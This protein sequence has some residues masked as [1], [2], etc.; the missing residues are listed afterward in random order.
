MDRRRGRIDRKAAHWALRL[1]ARACGPAERRRLDRWLERDPAH[2]T[3]LSEA[4]R[5]L[6]AIDRFAAAPPPL[7]AASSAGVRRSGRRPQRRLAAGLCG[8]AAAACLCL[9]LALGYLW[10]G[11]PRILIAADAATGPG[12]LREVR[13]PDGSAVTLGPE[14]AVAWDFEAGGRR[15]ELLAGAAVFSVVPDPDAGE[16]ASDRRFS[17]AAGAG[18]VTA[19]GTRFLVELRGDGVE[20]AVAEHAVLVSLRRAGGEARRE[21]VQGQGLRYGPAG[22]GAV[23]TL[24]PSLVAAWQRGRLVFD[25]VPLSEVVEELSRYRRGSILVADG[26]LAARRVSGVFSAADPDAVLR[27]IAREMSA[28]VLSVTPLVTLLY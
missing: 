22:I 25:A 5:A 1:E 6:A 2:R 12:E 3:A 4:R 17:V 21:L 15:V 26:A 10:I 20:V 19:L 9:V 13:L 7:P 28:E 16:G 11:D 23:R 24:D 14:S 27:T 8:A 18:L